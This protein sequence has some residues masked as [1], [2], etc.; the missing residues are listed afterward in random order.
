[1]PRT[2]DYFPGEREEEALL[3]L[4]GSDMPAKN[5]E[6]TYVS[7]SGFKFFEEGI[8]KTLSSSSGISAD[9]H[10]ILRQLI[11][12]ADGGGPFE[13][14]ATGAVEDQGPKPFPTASIWYTDVTRTKKIVEQVIT[15][16][17]NRT[18]AI[19]VWRAYDVDGVTVLATVS[20]SITYD[21]I[22]ETTR[23]RTIA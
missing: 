13:G 4:S 17:G 7:G 20:D 6:I 16:N 21:S 3:I 11:H 10:K 22:F 23:T 2:P 8:V 14:F 12:L 19:E 1:M 15:Y 9:D 18:I 5:G